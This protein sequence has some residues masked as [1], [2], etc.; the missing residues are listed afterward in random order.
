[1]GEGNSLTRLAGR[2]RSGVIGS[3]AYPKSDADSE[4][5]VGGAGKKQETGD[6]K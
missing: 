3:E 6:R 2:S 1:M 4:L 5:D